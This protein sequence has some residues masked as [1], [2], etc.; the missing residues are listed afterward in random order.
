MSE[1]SKKNRVARCACGGVVLETTGE[2]IICAACYCDD[3]QAAAAEIESLPNAQP[4]R[5][6]LGGTEF[7]LFRKDRMRCR[8][9]E[10]H[11]LDH[12]LKQGSSTRRVVA[13][14]CN[15][16]MFLDFQKG[17]WFS[18]HRDR[19]DG[20]VPLLQARIQTKFAPDVRKLPSSTP[21][22]SAYPFKLIGKL[23]LARIAMLLY[24]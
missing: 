5:D 6:G 8:S 20:D 21:I 7:L 11:L 2:P 19:F 14:C 10:E 24:K 1:P 9:G 13:S 23:V 22:Y 15:S 3:C 18:M 16:F 4:V 17:H 12:K